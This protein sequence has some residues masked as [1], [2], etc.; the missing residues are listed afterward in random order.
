MSG[1]DIV[2]RLIIQQ[3][4]CPSC[5]PPHNR[6]GSQIMGT[7]CNRC[8]AEEAALNHIATL[9][10]DLAAERA[11]VERLRAAG[12]ALVQLICLNPNTPSQE[13]WDVAIAAWEEA[14]R[15]R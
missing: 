4:S 9:A 8:E 11:E 1:D 12:A 3:Q 6:I 13:D 14:S 15:E 5:T 10:A 7:W 2:K